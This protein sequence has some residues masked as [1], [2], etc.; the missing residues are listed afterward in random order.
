MSLLLPNVLDLLAALPDNAANADAR[1]LAAAAG[2]VES[3]E[4]L[5]AALTG[6][7]Q[8]WLA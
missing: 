1:Q 4:E 7:V 5:D 6:V 3:S 8:S 2:S